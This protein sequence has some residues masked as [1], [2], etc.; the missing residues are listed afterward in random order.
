VRAGHHGH[1][2]L[3][4]GEIGAIETH[5]MRSRRLNI[6]NECSDIPTDDVND[7]HRSDVV[8]VLSGN[9]A[10]YIHSATAER[11]WGRR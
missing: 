9:D 5:G 11:V 8:C 10:P 2:V 4:D 7:F 1:D 3:T 6:T